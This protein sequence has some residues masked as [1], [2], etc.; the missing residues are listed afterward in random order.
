M[1]SVRSIS[2]LARMRSS[3][4]SRCWISRAKTLSIASEVPVT[5]AALTTSGISIHARRK[6]SGVIVPWQ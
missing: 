6:A 2:P 4:R 3:A 1:L 5:V